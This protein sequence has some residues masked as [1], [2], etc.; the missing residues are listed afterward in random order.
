MI[1]GAFD[2]SYRYDIA[3]ARCAMIALIALKHHR[4]K[5]YPTICYDI[6]AAVIND[7]HRQL[8]KP[9]LTK[10]AFSKKWRLTCLQSV[11]RTFIFKPSFGY[12]RLEATPASVM[13]FGTFK[14]LQ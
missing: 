8:Q 11:F 4:A 9:R 6:D 3:I 10:I 13:S 1:G 12:S 2:V 14:L 7:D 5:S